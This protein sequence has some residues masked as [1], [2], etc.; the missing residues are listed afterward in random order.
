VIAHLLSVSGVR[1]SIKLDRPPPSG[2]YILSHLA[3]LWVMSRICG[4]DGARVASKD[5]E[6]FPP[7]NARGRKSGV[8]G[9]TSRT[10][11]S[12][13]SHDEPH[14]VE[15]W[16]L[17]RANYYWRMRGETTQGSPLSKR[18]MHLTEVLAFC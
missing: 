10:P 4:V 17:H 6:P 15:I 1:C 18:D 16:F 3:V 11:T 13:E 2:E 5:S 8:Q 12:K 9:E 14:L 7:L